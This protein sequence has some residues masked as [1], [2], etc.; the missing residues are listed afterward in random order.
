MRAGFLLRPG[1]VALTAAVVLFAIACFTL[2]APWQLHRHEEKRAVNEAVRASFQVPARPIESLPPDA[3]EWLQVELTGTYLVEAETVARLRT[4][5]GEPA[6]EVLTPMRLTSGQTVLV[7]RGFVRPARSGT[8]GRGNQVPDYAAPPGGVVT[9]AGRLR[10]DEGNADG[11]APVTDGG[12]RQ[13]YSINAPAISELTGLPLRAG[14]VQLNAEQPGVLGPLPLP[15][16][17]AGPYLAYGLQ[18]IAFGVIALVGWVLVVRR[19]LA[20]RAAGR[21][22]TGRPTAGRSAAGRAATATGAGPAGDGG[23]RG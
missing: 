23:E 6:F 21:S 16:L 9:V 19:E 13:V 14:Y 4:V 3:G 15:R 12:R 11:R 17:D 18:W 5:Q 22:A 20:E 2:L 10:R 1:W 8:G 7:D